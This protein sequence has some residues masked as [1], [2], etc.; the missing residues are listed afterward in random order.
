MKSS[1]IEEVKRRK[2]ELLRELK[3][4]DTFLSF[5]EGRNGDPIPASLKLGQ[6][7]PRKL[8]SV[9]LANL[10]SEHFGKDKAA[11]ITLGEMQSSFGG[12][13]LTPEFEK[14]FLLW[15]NAGRK[16]LNEL[17]DLLASMEGASV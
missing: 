16:A 7:V 10:L 6:M 3:A 9:R 5:Y 11:N 14:E 15:R 2:N 4:I 13:P 12:Y 8:M 17:K 1:A